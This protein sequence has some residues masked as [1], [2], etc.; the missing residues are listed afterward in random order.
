MQSIYYIRWKDGLGPS[1]EQLQHLIV[2]KDDPT[3]RL[4]ISGNKAGGKTG[5]GN[6]ME[7]SRREFQGETL[8][9]SHSSQFSNKT[10]EQYPLELENKS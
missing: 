8:Q 2:E 7:A 3:R 1:Y 4:K 10:T 9:V 5:E 6:I